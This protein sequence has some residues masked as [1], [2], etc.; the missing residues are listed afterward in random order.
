MSL[1]QAHR[2]AVILRCGRRKPLLHAVPRT[3][4]P[5]PY[6]GCSPARGGAACSSNKDGK[7]PPLQTD[8]NTILLAMGGGCES[9]EHGLPRSVKPS[10]TS[11]AATPTTRP[12][13]HLWLPMAIAAN[14]RELYRYIATLKPCIYRLNASWPPARTSHYPLAGALMSSPLPMQLLYLRAQLP[15][16]TR[17]WPTPWR[18]VTTMRVFSVSCLFGAGAGVTVHTPVRG[19]RRGALLWSRCCRL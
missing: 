13:L 14:R 8:P 2:N 1:L 4:L 9:S 5:C 16:A 10:A 15:S 19:L 18:C 12:L 11:R 17:T 3:S 7:E 6:R